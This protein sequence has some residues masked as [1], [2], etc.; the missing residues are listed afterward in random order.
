MVR[1]SNDV[2]VKR[3]RRGRS[4]GDYHLGPTV[5]EVEVVHIAAGWISRLLLQGRH[6]GAARNHH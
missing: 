4:N 2:R 1:E 5:A 6:D 3:Y